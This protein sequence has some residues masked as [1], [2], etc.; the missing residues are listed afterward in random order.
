MEGHL[1]DVVL[2]SRDGTEHRGHANVL[3]AASKVLKTL[4]GGPF[5][6]ADSVQRGQPIEVCA[7]DASVGALLDFI[8][9]GQPQV[10]LEDSIELLALADAYNLPQ[11]T[12]AIQTR[13]R[14]SIEN[15]PVATALKLL[16]ESQGLQALKNACAEKVA[17]NF[18]ACAQHPDFLQLSPTQLG[19]IMQRDDLNVSRED[20]VLTSLWK[21]LK[22]SKERYAFLGLLLMQIDFRSI[23]FQNL[24]RIDHFAASV[25]PRGV[26][27]QLE[28]GKALQAHRKRSSEIADQIQPKRRCL[29]HWSPDLGASSTGA[30]KLLS[31]PCWSMCC[32]EGAI[33][34][35]TC[36]GD[37]ASILCLKPG[38]S[39][40]L[41]VAGHG[42][43]VDGM[44]DLGRGCSVF[45]MLT[46]E[47][48]VRDHDNKRLVS[49]ANG[50]GQLDRRSDS[51]RWHVSPR[52]T[53]YYVNTRATTTGQRLEKLVGTTF[54]AVTH[55]LPFKVNVKAMFVTEE[56][57]CYLADDCGRIWRLS[58]GE[59]EPAVV[60]EVTGGPASNIMKLFVTEE[61]KIYAADWSQGKVWAFHP[62]DTTCIEVLQCPEGGHPKAIAAQERSL[63]VSWLKKGPGGRGWVGR[64]DEYLLPPELKLE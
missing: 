38:D 62:G 45:V 1:C 20:A 49:F 61:G 31:R 30:R 11:L 4:L 60:G 17:L 16:Q 28:A 23:S 25:G 27:L 29:R 10:P 46:G 64:T 5:R 56:E 63:Y 33:Y 7:S 6:E 58:P 19:Q 50:F 32:H 34:A 36:D 55:P 9:G 51:G 15:A 22:E 39:D 26:E 42:A 18:E 13:L 44:N 59:T 3:S 48:V 47:I 52:G 21:W 40:P 12:E 43:R 24:V 14:A 54:Q 35:A 53:L 57:A 41:V 8:Y 2:K 37:S